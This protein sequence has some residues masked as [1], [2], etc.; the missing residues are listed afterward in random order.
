MTHFSLTRSRGCAPSNGYRVF[1]DIERNRRSVSTCNLA[2][3]VGPRN[4]VVW[5]SND[6]LGMGA[7]C[8]CRLRDDS[9]R[10]QNGRRRRRDPQHL[11]YPSSRRRTRSRARRPAPQTGGPSIHFGL[12][13]E[14]D[15]DR[16]NCETA[17]RLPDSVGRDES[18]FDDRGSSAIGG[19]KDKSGVTTTSAIWRRCCVRPPQIGRS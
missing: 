17:S 11:R 16:H 9:G 15:R 13:L 1:A 19:S 5:C 3:T 4:V 8:K 6:Y 7:E 2:R 14:P 12:C 18:Q 10:D